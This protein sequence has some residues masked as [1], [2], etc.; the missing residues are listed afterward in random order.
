M[1]TPVCYRRSASTGYNLRT[2]YHIDRAARTAEENCLCCGLWIL[3]GAL[4]WEINSLR[5]PWHHWIPPP[6]VPPLSLLDAGGGPC[7]PMRVG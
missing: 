2:L 4:P 1:C 5:G 6:S 7:P 3:L